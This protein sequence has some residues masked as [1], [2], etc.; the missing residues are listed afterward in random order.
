MLGNNCPLHI[1]LRWDQMRQILSAICGTVSERKS[2]NKLKWGEVGKKTTI[3]PFLCALFP[4]RL[5]TSIL[6][7]QTSPPSSL[8]A[9]NSPVRFTSPSLCHFSYPHIPHSSFTIYNIIYIY[10]IYKYIIIK[11]I[12]INKFKKNCA[13]KCHHG[14]LPYNI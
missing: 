13:L 8:S 12:I 14:T 10:N 7:P 1:C 2:G 9:C 3:F 11:T 4:N 5:V 6:N